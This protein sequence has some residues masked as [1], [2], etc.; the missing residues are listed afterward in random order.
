MPGKK[1]LP[2]AKMKRAFEGCF[3]P[4]ARLGD[5]HTSGIDERRNACIGHPN[6]VSPAFDGPDRAEIE[7]VPVARGIFPPSVVGDHADK[8]LFPGQILGAVET[9]SGLKTDNGQNAEG[10]IRQEKMGVLLAETVGAA[11]P[12]K[13]Q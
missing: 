9:K 1:S 3:L 2:P 12:P 6:H 7:V 5:D 13:L 11:V 10:I 8:T 4:P